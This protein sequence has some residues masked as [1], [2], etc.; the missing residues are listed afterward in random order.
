MLFLPKK[1]FTEKHSEFFNKPKILHHSF[2]HY[3]IMLKYAQ[4][5]NLAFT[6]HAHFHIVHTHALYS[7]NFLLE[8][9]TYHSLHFSSY[10]FCF[11]TFRV[12]HKIYS[13]FILLTHTHIT[14]TQ[15]TFEVIT[16]TEILLKT[17]DLCLC[18][19]RFCSQTTSKG[20]I[21]NL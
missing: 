12:N 4:H 1:Y 21:N 7:L 20:L 17:S 3:F 14:F 13:I 19:Y 11:A 16:K 8:Y 9:L 15:I 10:F 18:R 5:K 2:Y 6:L